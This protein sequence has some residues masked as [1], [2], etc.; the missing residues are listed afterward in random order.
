M[1]NTVINTPVAPSHPEGQ[2]HATKGGH[3]VAFKAQGNFAPEAT[4]EVI[5]AV[6]PW[7]PNTPGH[8]FYAAILASKSATVGDVLSVGKEAGFKASDI[9]GHLRWL[10]TWGGSY[11]RVAGNVY[12]APAVSA[13]EV[14][15]PVA[16]PALAAPVAPS[17]QAEAKVAAKAAS[18]ARARRVVRA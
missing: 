1:V 6:N 10:F 9:Q 12:A 13:P 18:K 4:F 15:A 3:Y 17:A 11:I 8:R 5:S 14:Q 2:G 7:R 16:A